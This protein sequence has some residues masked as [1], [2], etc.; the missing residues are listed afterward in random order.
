MI[1]INENEENATFTTHKSGFIM[2][3]NCE[4]WNKLNS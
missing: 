2:K 3:E 1:F 4:G